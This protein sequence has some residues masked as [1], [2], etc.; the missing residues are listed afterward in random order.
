MLLYGD[1]G[2]DTHLYSALIG[3]WTRGRAGRSETTG[4]H[5]WSPY[6]SHEPVVEVTELLECLLEGWS[7]CWVI[8]L[9]GGEDWN[10][11]NAEAET[12][13]KYSHSK[14]TP[15]KTP[16][17]AESHESNN[18]TGTNR[19]PETGLETRSEAGWEHGA[20]RQTSNQ[21][22]KSQANIKRHGPRWYDQDGWD[23]GRNAWIINTEQ[24]VK[25]RAT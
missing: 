14:N 3:D 6:G 1:L 13:H 7:P 10:V 23:Q 25:L 2:N 16:S 9:Q 21:E 19:G 22:E 12:V 15:N 11:G 24:E 5:W 18:Q 17:A 20:P 8:L 4:S